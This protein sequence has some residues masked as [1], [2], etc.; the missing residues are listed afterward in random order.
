M[1]NKTYEPCPFCGGTHIKH[2]KCT[3][4]VR[5]A[6]CFCTGPLIGKFLIEGVTEEQAAVNSWNRR[7]TAYAVND[8]RGKG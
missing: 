2:D 3:S 7:I 4:R 1:E 6:D 8:A 5:C